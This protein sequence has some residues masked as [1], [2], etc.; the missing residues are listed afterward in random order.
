MDHLGKNIKGS[1]IAELHSIDPSQIKDLENIKKIWIASSSKNLPEKILAVLNDY[2][3][4]NNRM[5]RLFSGKVNRSHID[6]I[7]KIIEAIKHIKKEDKEFNSYSDVISQWVLKCLYE[8]NIS[9]P[10]GTLATTIQ[11][12]SLNM[13]SLSSNETELSA[14]ISIPENLVCGLSQDLFKDPVIDEYNISIERKWINNSRKIQNI[15][16]YDRRPYKTP[17]NQEFPKNY[18]LQL[19]AEIFKAKCVGLLNAPKLNTK[20]SP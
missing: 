10:K 7:E 17:I 9:N 8:M 1:N 4:D 2:T 13:P 20:P 3:A 14:D 11:F 16:P 6:E 12:L 5:Y 19:Q 15:S 18:L